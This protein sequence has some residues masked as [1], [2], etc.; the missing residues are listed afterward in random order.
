MLEAIGDHWLLSSIG[1]FVGFLLLVAIYDV[2]IQKKHTIRHNFPI[3]GHIRYWLERIGPEMR[4]YWVANDKEEMP[5]NRDERSWIYASAKGENNNFGFGS[6]E[7][8]YSIGYPIIKHAAFPFPEHNA[9]YASRRQN[10]YPMLKSDGRNPPTVTALPAT[11]RHQ[12][13]GNV[14]RIVGRQCGGGN[15]PRRQSGQLFSQ[16]W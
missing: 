3:V 6:T 5:F 2:F 10:I 16:Y 15:E 14:V 8:Q 11:I 1:T 12:Y 9:K 7:Q 4:Q 13:L